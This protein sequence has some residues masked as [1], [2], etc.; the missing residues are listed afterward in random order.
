MLVLINQI[1]VGVLAN[2]KFSGDCLLLSI[3]LTIYVVGELIMKIRIIKESLS[4]ASVDRQF[5]DNS[6]GFIVGNELG[7][8]K[9]GVVFAIQSRRSRKNYALKVVSSQT[10]QKGFDR[11]KNNY[12][13]IKKFVDQHEF[14]RFSTQIE[15]L[16]IVHK[17]VSDY[18][19]KVH[20]I[21]EHPQSGDLYIVMEKLI[22]LSGDESKEWMGATSAM[23]WLLKKSPGTASYARS[24]EDRIIDD[25]SDLV[26]NSEKARQ[27]VDL[28]SKSPEHPIIRTNRQKYEDY[29]IKGSDDDTNAQQYISFVSNFVKKQAKA[30]IPIAANLN[31]ID[32]LDL[33]WQESPEARRVINASIDVIVSA[34][35]DGQSQDI[36]SDPEFMAYLLNELFGVIFSQ[37]HSFQHIKGGEQDALHRGYGQTDDIFKV[38]WEGEGIKPNPIKRNYIP[39]N[40]RKRS[41]T[42]PP[43]G[44]KFTQDEK[45]RNIIPKNLSSKGFWEGFKNSPIGQKYRFNP[46]VN[47]IEELAM[48]WN[49]QV[50]DL[51]D[52]NVMKRSDGQVVFVDVGLFRTEPQQT[53][54]KPPIPPPPSVPSASPSGGAPWQSGRGI[55]ESKKRRIKVKI[56]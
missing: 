10:P 31:I 20:E 12:N 44:M 50:V 9:F 53:N 17:L 4:K 33:L 23:A 55:F 2:Q 15:D 11:E 14:S 49:I 6:L 48:K 1:Q 19:P 41:P 27:I 28:I 3:N 37:K 18:L 40:P 39:K 8:G 51:H 26:F 56:T 32:N 36:S 16:T 34:Y 54:L 5:V 7:R 21:V 46:I 43:S 30:N 22:P 29:I 52:A 35:D 13:V 24:L 42:P 25:T 38:D 47:A 45:G